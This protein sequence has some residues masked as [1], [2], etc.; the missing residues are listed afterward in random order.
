[1]KQTNIFIEM[2]IMWLLTVKVILDKIR[3]NFL[4]IS[5]GR[6]SETAIAHKNKT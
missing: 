4:Q 1:M 5:N 6:K 2:V 3:P